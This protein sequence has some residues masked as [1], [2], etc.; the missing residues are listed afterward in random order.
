MASE[1]IRIFA[2]VNFIIF[3]HHWGMCRSLCCSRLVQSA[4][5]AELDIEGSLLLGIPDPLKASSTLSAS[6]RPIQPTFAEIIAQCTIKTLHFLFNFGKFIV[7][8]CSVRWCSGIQELQQLCY[9]L[10]LADHVLEFCILP[11]VFLWCG[12]FFWPKASF[13][14]TVRCRCRCR[15]SE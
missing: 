4:A 8:Q 9:Y 13:R 3:A 7:F 6:A 12:P 5:S 15:C 14:L 11:S 1:Y 10:L 2:R